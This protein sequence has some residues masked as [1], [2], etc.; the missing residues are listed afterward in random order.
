[1]T[2]LDV[3]RQWLQEGDHAEKLLLTV[4]SSLVVATL[5]WLRKSIAGGVQGLFAR[6][7]NRSPYR[8]ELARYRERL[9]KD[10]LRIRHAWMK[11]E[12]TLSDILVPV[13]VESDP[14][15]G[16]VESLAAVLARHFGPGEVTHLVLT[17]GPGSG[18]SVALRLAARQLWTQP[19]FDEETPRIPVLITFSE[20]RNAGYQLA[21]AVADSLRARGF[22]P[23]KGPDQ[24]AMAKEFTAEF[25]RNG[26]L[27]VLIDALDELASAD[28]VTAIQ[29][30]RMELK[31]YSSTPVALTCRTAAWHGQLRGLPHTEVRLVD[32]SPAAIRQFIRAWGF[33]PPKSSTELLGVIESQPHIGTL[34]RNPLMLTIVAFL[35]SQPRYRLPENRAQFYEV[36]SRALLE[37]WDQHENPMRANQYDRPHKEILLGRLAYAHLC[38]SDPDRDIEEAEALASIAEGMHQLGMVRSGNVRM[39]EEIVLNS[40]LLVRLPPSGLRFPHQTYM[41]YFAALHLLRSAGADTLLEHYGKEKNRWREVVLLYCGLNADVAQN[42]RMI[43]ELLQTDSVETALATLIDARAVDRELVAEVLEATRKQ[44]SNAPSRALITGL[45]SLSAN[46]LSDYAGE[47]RKILQNLLRRASVEQISAD[48]L[49]DLV[50]ACLRRPDEDTIRMV[51]DR[52]GQLALRKLLPSMGERAIVMTTKILGQ[53]GLSLGKKLEWIEGI[54]D[55]GAIRTLYMVATMKQEEPQLGRAAAVALAR[56]SQSHE[57]WECLEETDQVPQPF[58]PECE[59]AFRKWKWPFSQPSQIQGKRL[60]FQLA[61]EVAEAF[62]G[63]QMS[64]DQFAEQNRRIA[65]LACALHLERGYHRRNTTIAELNEVLSAGPGA[66]YSIWR[67]IESVRW[68]KWMEAMDPDRPLV[69]VAQM[70]AFL[71][72]IVVFGWSL[73]SITGALG[74][75]VT[76]ALSYLT[77]TT[78]ITLFALKNGDDIDIK[79]IPILMS[80]TPV[81]PTAYALEKE[82]RYSWIFMLSA[83]YILGYELAAI[84]VQANMVF[85]LFVAFSPLSLFVIFDIMDLIMPPLFATRRTIRLCK[86]LKE[87]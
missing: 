61:H 8:P 36:C 2:T 73:L 42:S 54:R 39:L 78:A 25:L 48:L 4:V 72:H 5:T 68:A 16:G 41:E 65:F 59:R 33:R 35:Y 29:R 47:A 19:S 23:P 44:L 1:M 57:F 75:P 84:M 76:F 27:L 31:E 87:V 86:W 43:R 34:A 64:A 40:G 74:V 46:P 18:K 56:S 28:R 50:L 85:R 77:W 79:D 60:A 15:A 62:E 82:W 20:Y 26:R 55:A 7:W 10:T 37:E 11:E 71:P 70:L 24:G 80:M 67:K 38:G 3:V 58:D 21:A 45:G 6:L 13:S 12:Q 51:I 83:L 9:E 53:Q 22:H 81:I 32:F 17:G 52:A 30:L 63:D 69:S 49:E 14:Q 66:L